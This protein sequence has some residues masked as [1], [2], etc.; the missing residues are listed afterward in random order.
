MTRIHYYF[1]IKPHIFTKPNSKPISHHNQL[2]IRPQGNRR[3]SLLLEIPHQR[4]L[5][6][7]ILDILSQLNA[8]NLLKQLR[9]LLVHLDNRQHV[10]LLFSDTSI[11]A[12]DCLFVDFWWNLVLDLI[13]SA[14]LDSYG[15]GPVSFNGFLLQLRGGHSAW[16][17]LEQRVE[18]RLG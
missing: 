14:V 10:R 16:E 7:R 11:V 2:P 18:L 15:H 13:L 6:L 9:V 4:Q 1:N 8:L 5:F 12:N 17:L 3:P